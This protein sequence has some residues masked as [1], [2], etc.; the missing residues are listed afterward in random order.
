M[1]VRSKLE[2]MKA[3][4]DKL[5]LFVAELSEFRIFN[6]RHHFIFFG[7]V[8]IALVKTALQSRSLLSSISNSLN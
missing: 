2:R 1:L 7:C 8:N 3:F 6:E 5:D 4:F